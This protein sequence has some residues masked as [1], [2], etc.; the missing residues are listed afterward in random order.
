MV[1]A[2]LLPFRDGKYWCNLGQL[3]TEGMSNLEDLI[4]VAAFFY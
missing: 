2:S 3:I 1:L 4:F